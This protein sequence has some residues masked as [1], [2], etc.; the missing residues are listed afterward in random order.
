MFVNFSSQCVVEVRV[1][2]IRH[3][4]FGRRQEYVRI[5]V[6]IRTRHPESTRCEGRLRTRILPVSRRFLRKVRP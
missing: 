1:D 6:D 5:D 2:G 4:G 3:G